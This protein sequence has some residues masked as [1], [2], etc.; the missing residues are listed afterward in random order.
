MTAG[1]GKLQAPLI[2]RNDFSSEDIV[3]VDDPLRQDTMRTVLARTSGESGL[4][5]TPVMSSP[6]PLKATPGKSRANRAAQRRLRMQVLISCCIMFA[7]GFYAT[8]IFPYCPSMTEELRRN[9]VAVGLYSG[10]LFTAQSTGNLITAY[11]WAKLSNKVGR[12]PCLLVGLT[13][14]MLA[15][16]L[17]ASTTEFWTAVAIRFLSGLM[18]SNL[19]LMRTA[20]RESFHHEEQEDTWAFSTLSVAFGA[21]SVA[22][23]SLGGLLYNQTVPLLGYWQLPWTSPNLFSTMLY[24]PLLVLT[25]L[26]M[27]ETAFLTMPPHL[28]GKSG[29]AVPAGA[30]PSLLRNFA[31]VLLLIVGGG[32]SYVFT[33]WEITYPL[34]ARIPAENFG[35]D[36]STA[37]VG[38]TFL[39][40][41][42]ALMLYSL[43]IFPFIASRVRVIRIWIL[44]WVLPVIAIPLFPRLLTHMCEMDASLLSLTMLNYGTQALL[45]VLLGSGFISIQLMLNSYVSKLP[46]SSAQLALANSMLVSTQALVRA[47]SPMANGALFT[48]GL[49]IEIEDPYSLVSRA[50]PFDTLGVIGI[51]TCMVCAMAFER[52]S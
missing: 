30:S 18:N 11:K 39:M 49:Q 23:P 13:S 36:W 42:F 47:V 31:F 41:S 5:L 26:T 24:V 2:N 10:L 35:E 12:R 32:H 44:S 7:E 52:R 38:V 6:F 34:I 19:A 8:Q 28:A 1:N 15:S 3:D 22:G 16:I 46:N 21:A 25:T 48:L 43:F 29:L 33:G 14:N 50:L 17:M 51:L 45:S 37:Q 4:L 40:G 20:L 9:K 27:P